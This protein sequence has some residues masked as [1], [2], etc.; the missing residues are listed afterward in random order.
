MKAREKEKLGV[1]RMLQA[2]IK[3][4]EIDGRKELDEAGVISVLSS[5][6]RKVKDQVSSYREAGREELLAVAQREQD[7]VASFLPSALSATEL[8]GLVREAITETG[9]TS[10]RD[11][12]KVMKVIMPKVAGRADGAQVSATVK[13]LLQ[14]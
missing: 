6:A 1:L 4:A 9:A 11:L 7:L 14:E 3:Q 2:A 12:G 10:P 8:A 13:E 5:Y